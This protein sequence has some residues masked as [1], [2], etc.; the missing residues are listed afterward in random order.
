MVEDREPPAWT[1]GFFSSKS[2]RCE[3]YPADF[4]FVI[5]SNCWYCISAVVE[6]IRITFALDYQIDCM[7]YCSC[8]FAMKWRPGRLRLSRF[9]LLILLKQVTVTHTRAEGILRWTGFHHSPYFLVFHSRRAI[10]AF[11]FK[12]S[13]MEF[14]ETTAY[15]VVSV[16]TLSE[17]KVYTTSCLCHS[18]GYKKVS[19]SVAP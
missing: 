3:V 9:T 10:P 16:R 2:L 8:L 1:L 7:S 15:A 19:R 13:F 12:I 4:F 11:E 6:R 5:Y 17:C 14:L 18:I